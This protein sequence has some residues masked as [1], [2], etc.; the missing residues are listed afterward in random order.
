MQNPIKNFWKFP[1]PFFPNLTNPH[2][3][4]FEHYRLEGVVMPYTM[5]DYQRECRYTVNGHHV[6]ILICDRS[7]YRRYLSQLTV[8]EIL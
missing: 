2:L 4:L 5:E 8:D 7:Q 6:E 1:L 3:D